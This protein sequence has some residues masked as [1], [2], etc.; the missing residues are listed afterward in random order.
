METNTATISEIVTAD[1][2]AARVLEAYG[3]DFCF[4]GDKTLKEIS[5]EMHLNNAA[6]EASVENL[7]LHQTKW[8]YKI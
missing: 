4:S 3:I 2:R 1:Y 8:L 5:E 6:L 7:K